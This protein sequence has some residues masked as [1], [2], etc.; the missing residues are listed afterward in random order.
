MPRTVDEQDDIVIE[1]RTQTPELIQAALAGDGYE[2]IESM[3]ATD[4]P[5][6]QSEENPAEPVADDG[7]EAEAEEEGEEPAGAVQPQ[8]E[9]ETERHKLS[10][11]QRAKRARERLQDENAE[12][13][14]RIEAIEQSQNKPQSRPHPQEEP[15]EAA[16]VDAA[17]SRP[18]PDEFAE[19]AFDP[20]FLDAMVDWRI[21]ERDR[22]RQA[23][24]REA[25]AAQAKAR[26][27]SERHTANERW[28]AKIERSKEAHDDFQTVM[29][30]AKDLPVSMAAHT[31][32]AAS[33][34]PAEVLY[35]LATHPDEARRIHTATLINQTD[36]PRVAARKQ[37][38][39][40]EEIEKIEAALAG[41][42]PDKQP[43]PAAPP[44]GGITPISAPKPKPQPIEPMGARGGAS[45]K[46][47]SDLSIDELRQLDTL[48]Y[49][50][51]FKEEH[52]HYPI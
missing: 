6:Q 52:G 29:E 33:E 38:L 8:P 14:R 21:G 27:E 10:G 49:R 42:P 12:L 3:L 48:E 34:E 5:E 9:G 11:A 26:Q 36:S 30:Q 22:Q 16:T 20:G 47:L 39:A 45:R 24:A 41:A 23:A 31:V 7:A 37:A 44:A 2:V 19:G 28:T 1:S 43:S 40:V 35:W 51:L 50:T 18:D 13:R 4:K 15:A 32:I 46:K 25:E 17:Q